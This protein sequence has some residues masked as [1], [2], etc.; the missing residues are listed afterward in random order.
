MTD[1]NKYSVLRKLLVHLAQKANILQKGTCFTFGLS[2]NKLAIFHLPNVYSSC[3]WSITQSKEHRHFFPSLLSCE[4][5]RDLAHH[6]TAASAGKKE[7]G[8][9]IG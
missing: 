2:K 6:H 1:L 5:E 9:M 7:G 3:D 8:F 4:K